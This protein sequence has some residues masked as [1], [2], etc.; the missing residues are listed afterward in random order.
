MASRLSRT[1]FYSNLL[2]K[3]APAPEKGEEMP[4]GAGLHRGYPGKLGNVTTGWA[5][6]K[7]KVS[8][9]SDWWVGLAKRTLMQ[10]RSGRD[11]RVAAATASCLIRKS[12]EGLPPHSDALLTS[13]V[14]LWSASWS[15]RPA[16]SPPKPRPSW[17][18][19]ARSGWRRLSLGAAFV[20]LA[21]AIRRPGPGSSSLS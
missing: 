3:F 21:R 12:S 20:S 11:E 17:R 4:L 13:M 7:D 2:G 18:K 16:G 10:E 8:T 9:S 6:R 1:G 5:R 19:T 15:L 14:V